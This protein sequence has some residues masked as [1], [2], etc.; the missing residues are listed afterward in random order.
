ML[1]TDQDL[2][3]GLQA[4]TGNDHRNTYAAHIWNS[5]TN[6]SQIRFFYAYKKTDA[7]A[8]AR[9]YV[10]RFMDSN[11]QIVSITKEAK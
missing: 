10:I 7:L 5:R 8:L 11:Y 3:F 4:P 9:E 2:T 6:S 1:P